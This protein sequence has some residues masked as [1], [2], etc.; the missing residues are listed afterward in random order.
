[1]K[2]SVSLDPRKEKGESN[3]NL[4]FSSVSSISNNYIFL[5]FSNLSALSAIFKP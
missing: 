3:E 4:N 2:V 1:M 5:D